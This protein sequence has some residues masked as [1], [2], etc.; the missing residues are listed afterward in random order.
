MHPLLLPPHTERHNSSS[1]CFG[2]EVRNVNTVTEKACVW[3][4]GVHCL[5]TG[6]ICKLPQI[7]YPLMI[8]QLCKRKWKQDFMLHRC[9]LHNAGNGS[10]MIVLGFMAEG[11]WRGS[12]S[13]LQNVNWV[14]KI[15]L[16]YLS[17]HTFLPAEMVCPWLSTVYYL[18]HSV[19]VLRFNTTSHKEKYLCCGVL[20]NCF[21]RERNW[22]S[23]TYD[24]I[25][26]EYKLK[27]F[28][29]PWRLYCLFCFWY[30]K[31]CVTYGHLLPAFF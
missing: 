12:Y 18:N 11:K 27:C 4:H 8:P 15:E 1:H 22:Q 17:Y 6:V 31:Y 14:F 19:A 28:S 25:K 13:L 2:E 10:H 20:F 5:A 23:F 9:D 29:D 26:T 21:H 16:C 30:H 3:R 7:V 24:R